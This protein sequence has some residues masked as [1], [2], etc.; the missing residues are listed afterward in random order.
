MPTTRRAFLT[1]AAA[2]FSARA[3]GRPPNIIVIYADDLGFGDLGCYGSRLRTPHLDRMA[4]EGMRFTDFYSAN[5]L[6]SPSRAS[7]LTGR[8][9]TRVG[10]P[11]VLGPQA[12]DGLPPS[13]STLAELLK[14][15][16]Y[17][18]ACV[19]KWHLGHLPE[20]LPTRRGFDEYFGIPYSND[21]DPRLLLDNETVV[22]RSATLETLTSRYTERAVRFI[23][24]A[25][26]GP[27]FL[28]FAHTY[29]HIPLAAS[30]RFRNRSPLG[31]Y[32]DVVE[33]LDDS[34]GQVFAALRRHGLD[35]NTLVLFSSDNGPWYQGSPG[36]FRG[37]KGMT[38][39]GGVRAPFLARWPGRIPANATCSGIGSMMD[40][41]PT[42]TQL[43]G[44]PLPKSPVDGQDIWPMLSGKARDLP[45]D[46]LL[47]F[48]RWNLQCARWNNWK[49]HIA[50]Y[51][52]VRWSPAP[53]EGMVNLRLPAP[54]LYHLPNDPDES[55][56]VAARHPEVVN[57]ITDYMTRA[58]NG[59]PVEVREA[60]A[61][62][63]ARQPG[64]SATGAVPQLGQ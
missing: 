36:R 41:V 25:K 35:R 23:Y 50:R 7:L 34:V 47:F 59:F 53:K 8:Y 49:L 48:D 5:P 4:R 60:F 13:E 38:W 30:E 45:R 55:Y 18:T 15:T 9:P 6:C 28:Y 17:R 52:M 1:A 64:W 3:A 57:E 16:G 11:A 42:V 10:V 29:P 58:V 21:M 27:F 14:S 56:D 54:E 61:Q 37:R 19:G 33:E 20:Y 62:A 24:G 44:A 12:K 43:C 31:L 40:V 46:P 32:G 39:E 63:K 26:G 22:E 51:N 2:G